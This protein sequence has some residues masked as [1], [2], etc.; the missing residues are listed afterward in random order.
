MQRAFAHFHEIVR[1]DICSHNRINLMTG[2]FYA[3]FVKAAG[4]VRAAGTVGMHMVLLYC[5]LLKPV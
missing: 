1:S 2:S 3:C 4:A 5:R